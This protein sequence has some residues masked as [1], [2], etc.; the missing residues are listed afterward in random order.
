M[1]EFEYAQSLLA[2]A[3]KDLDALQGMTDAQTFAD[4]IFGFHV[5]QAV[6]KLL[7][8]WLNALDSEY[9]FSHDIS[10]LLM[11]LEELSSVY[12]SDL[13]KNYRCQENLGCGNKR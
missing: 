12:P 5:Q 13:T 2:M 10:V 8:A 3:Q 6:E 11:L 4:E 9:P 1:S 7:K